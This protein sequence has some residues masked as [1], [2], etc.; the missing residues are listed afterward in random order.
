MNCCIEWIS[1][2]HIVIARVLLLL[3]IKRINKNSN[4]DIFAPYLEFGGAI[5]LILV[6]FLPQDPLNFWPW[7]GRGRGQRCFSVA[8][9]SHIVNKYAKN[10]GDTISVGWLQISCRIK[11]FLLTPDYAYFYKCML[12]SVIDQDNIGYEKVSW[13][14]SFISC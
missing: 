5:L 10:G 13:S 1:N 14:R 12:K 4:K 11:Q 8:R 6:A 9:L 2:L 3:N 7:C